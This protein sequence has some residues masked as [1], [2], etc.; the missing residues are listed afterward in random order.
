MSNRLTIMTD[1]FKSRALR[2]ISAGA[3]CRC[4]LRLAG[5]CLGLGILAAAHA[6]DAA[7]T[8]DG[9][10][11]GLSHQRNEASVQYRPGTGD[12]TIAQGARIVRVHA[13]RDWVGAA[14]IETLLCHGSAAGPCVPIQ[15][16]QINTHKFDGL[17]AP[18]PFVMVHR[19]A[20][21]ASALPPVFVSGTVTVWFAGP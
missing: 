6:G 8:R 3:P 15:G 7:W 9:V 10:S 17:S 11:T 1:L 14:I 16:A 5:L 20:A 13:R 12:P 4:G 2:R 21:W 18:G 19:V